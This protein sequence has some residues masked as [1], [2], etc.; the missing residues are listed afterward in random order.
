MSGKSV[1]VLTDSSS[2]GF[3]FPLWHRYYS[4]QFGA[5]NLFVITSPD[6]MS[7]FRD[8]ELGGIWRVT[9]LYDDQARARTLTSAVSLLLTTYDLVIRVD[10]DEF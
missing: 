6:A 9:N 4:V 1:A 10:V 7:E 3:Y 5:N 2:A 8:L